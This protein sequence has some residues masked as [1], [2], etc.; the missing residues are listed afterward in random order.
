[1]NVHVYYYLGQISRFTEKDNCNQGEQNN[2]ARNI[3]WAAATN[4]GDTKSFHC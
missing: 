1:M 4:G 3:G 2:Y